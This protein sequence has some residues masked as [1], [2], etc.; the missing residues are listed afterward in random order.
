MA[1]SIGS[2]QGHLVIV[3]FTILYVPNVMC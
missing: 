2:Q 1:V 3:I